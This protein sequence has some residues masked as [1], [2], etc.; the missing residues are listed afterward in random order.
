MRETAE[1][2]ADPSALRGL[3]E[4]RESEQAGDVVRTEPK[5]RVRCSLSASGECRAL[6]ARTDPPG[7]ARDRRGTSGGRGRRSRRIHHRPAPGGALPG[8]QA[9]AGQA[10]RHPHRAARYPVARPVPDR[11]IKACGG[12]TG[13]TASLECLPPTVGIKVRREPRCSRSPRPRRCSRRRG[14]S[15]GGLPPRATGRASCPSRQTT[16]AGPRGSRRP[17]WRPRAGAGRSCA[18]LARRD[19]QDRDGGAAARRGL[20]APP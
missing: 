11:R 1:I 20:P 14:R 8:R 3:A 18:R 10:S 7:A 12:R 2:L 6:R 19:Q 9:T 4:A 15:R 16:V 17:A 13:H 5:Q